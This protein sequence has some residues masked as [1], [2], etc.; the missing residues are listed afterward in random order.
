[1]QKI[2]RCKSCSGALIEENGFFVCI[3]CGLV[4]KRYLKTNI[5]SYNTFIEK[6]SNYTRKYRF[7]C[8]LNELCGRLSFPNDLAKIM[9]ENKDR[10]IS[11]KSLKDILL[12]NK[13]L[14]KHSSKISAVLIWCGVLKPPLTTREIKHCC[15]IFQILDREISILSGKKPAFTFLIPIVLRLANKDVVANSQLLRKPSKLLTKK[16]AKCTL[17]AL[18]SLGYPAKVMV[19]PSD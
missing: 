17:D 10:I 6:P 15:D 14:K 13:K 16:Y 3:Y 1:M 19:G 5:L 8:L 4:Q 18:S 12:E 7:R 11:P 2:Q 9:L